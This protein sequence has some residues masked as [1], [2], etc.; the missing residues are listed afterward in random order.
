MIVRCVHAWGGA[1]RREWD[2]RNAVQ[3]WHESYRIIRLLT[4]TAIVFDGDY[5]KTLQRFALAMLRKRQHH[6]ALGCQIAQECRRHDGR[7]RRDDDRIDLE[8]LTQ[9]R[10]A[11]AVL[12]SHVLELQ[13]LQ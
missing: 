3:Q 12:Q 4:M 7:A 10:S 5:R 1:G 13:R 9:I 6:A 8:L 11:I 2:L